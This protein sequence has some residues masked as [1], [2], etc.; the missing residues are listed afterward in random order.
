MSHVQALSGQING[1]ST[2]ALEL[3][4]R[5]AAAKDAP[6]ITLSALERDGFLV[7]TSSQPILS[8]V[9]NL[10]G[11]GS[12]LAK[13]LETGFSRDLLPKRLSNLQLFNADSVIDQLRLFLDPLVPLAASWSL[14]GYHGR[15][16]RERVMAHMSGWSRFLDLADDLFRSK[17]WNVRYT[18]R[19]ENR[20]ETRNVRR[21]ENR[22]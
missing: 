3:K 7:I 13:R 2:L 15:P 9:A 21:L 22:T 8:L 17:T 20:V 12:T 18:V 16:P 14:R 10:P 6:K 5:I 4:P 19:E 1:H 11:G